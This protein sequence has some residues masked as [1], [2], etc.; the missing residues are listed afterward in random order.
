M[1]SEKLIKR[2]MSIDELAYTLENISH[3]DG[4]SAADYSDAE[5]VEEARYVLDLFANPSQ[6]HIN[7]E[8]LN[9][10]DGP[11]QAKWARSQVGKLRRFI[12]AFE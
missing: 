9:G 4:K 6:G 10:D 5:I 2:A 12:K 7:N 1:A 8:A 3:D 11:D